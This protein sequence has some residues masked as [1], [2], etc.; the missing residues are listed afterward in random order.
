MTYD[1]FWIHEFGSSGYATDFAGRRIK[2]IE[3]GK[4]SEFGW[5]I[6]HILP[7]KASV[8]SPDNITNLQ[9]THFRTN[10]EKAD[11]ITFKIDDTL[12]QVKRVKNLHQ[13]DCIAHYPYDNKKYCII[14]RDEYEEDDDDDYYDP[15]NPYGFW[16]DDDD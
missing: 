4:D 3:Y 1:E 5:S 12:Y 16:A 6:D 11:K 15:F 8:K 13:D 9:I 2:R 10:Q 14:I 7:K